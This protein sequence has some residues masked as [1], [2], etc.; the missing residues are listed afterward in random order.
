MKSFKKWLNRPLNE[1]AEE[2]SSVVVEKAKFFAGFFQGV[3]N[4]KQESNGYVKVSFRGKKGLD[5]VVYFYLEDNEVKA[6]SLHY[7]QTSGEI[8]SAKRD[9]MNMQE[10]EVHL[11][12]YL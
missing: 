1:N 3:S 10:L 8:P 7:K 9:G 11:R 6:D 4:F 2:Q 5:V 12:K